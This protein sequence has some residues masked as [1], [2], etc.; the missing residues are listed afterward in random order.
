VKNNRATPSPRTVAAQRS[1][2]FEGFTT[3]VAWEW[4]FSCVCAHVT[5]LQ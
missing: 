1:T 5:L 4:R 3:F 2:V